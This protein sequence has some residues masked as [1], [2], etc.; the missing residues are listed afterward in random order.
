MPPQP[1][2]K[3]NTVQQKKRSNTAQQKKSKPGQKK[4]PGKAKP[5]N[6]GKVPK[7][8]SKP[9]KKGGM[10]S[11]LIKLSLF[12][13]LLIV[14][15]LGYGMFQGGFK[16]ADGKVTK[17]SLLNSFKSSKNNLKKDFNKGVK[18]TT[19]QSKIIWDATKEK[20][21][22]WMEMS[23][24]SW[25]SLE[26]KVK[27]IG[28]VSSEELG[29]MA[30]GYLDD[31]KNMTNATEDKNNR[32]VVAHKTK[33]Y[34]DEILDEKERERLAQERKNNLGK[35][36]GSS[37]TPPRVEKKPSDSVVKNDNKFV[38]PKIKKNKPTRKPGGLTLDDSKA[39]KKNE[40][41]IR[42]NKPNRRVTKESK[43]P[44]PP[45]S[46]PKHMKQY[47]EGR[48]LFIEGVSHF[49]KANPNNPQRQRRKHNKLAYYK[50][51]KASKIFA[52]IAR[53]MDGHKEFEKI[54]MDTVRFHHA[55]GKTMLISDH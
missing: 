43:R 37:K 5:T 17:D 55:C 38:E 7:E 40:E 45:K 36:N 35:Q 18:F 9:K 41:A 48:K 44:S 28:E 30:D 39:G 42:K 25:A 49:K 4:D 21:L 14:G 16:D 19:E 20:R 32:K 1:K 6:E 29:S 52:K 54:S 3:S 27:E 23:K 10:I 22:S 13:G 24:D 53:K 31:F 26:K 15:Y 33:D 34:T 47:Y 2:K 51:K 8:K 46:E 50:F 11:K 12:V